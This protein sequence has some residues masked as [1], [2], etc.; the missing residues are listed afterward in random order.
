M[1]EGTLIP[2]L[3]EEGPLPAVEGTLSPA[4]L[5]PVPASFGE[6]FRLTLNRLKAS[7]PAGLELSGYLK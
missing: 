4:E 3:T 5:K 7:L 1:T 2:Q 6:R